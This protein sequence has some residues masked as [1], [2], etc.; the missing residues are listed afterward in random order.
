MDRTAHIL[1]MRREKN[2]MDEKKIIITEIILCHKFCAPAGWVS[3]EYK[4]SRKRH[5]LVYVLNGQALYQ[6]SEAEK[7]FVAK[8]GDILYLSPDL[9]YVTRCNKKVPF[10]HLT[11]NFQLSDNNALSTLPTR[12]TPV[13][14]QKIGQSFMHLVNE[15]TKRRRYY[16]VYS[17]SL[18]YELI[19]DFLNETDCVHDSY[20]KKLSPAIDYLEKHFCEPFPGKRLSEICGIS[21]TYFRRLFKKIYKESAEEYRTRL[22]VGKACDLLLSGMYSVG[23]IS[24]ECGYEDPAYFSRAFKKIMGKSPAQYKNEKM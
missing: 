23:K 1:K 22:R 9:S 19:G 11:V 24:A 4:N 2:E 20:R 15:W 8:E 7:S 14:K 5:G 12:M 13:N 16:Q 6:M 21:E 18:L 3:D 10:V 17:F